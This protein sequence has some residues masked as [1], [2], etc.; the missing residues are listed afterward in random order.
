MTQGFL[1]GR[2]GLAGRRAV[3][4]G[5]LSI[6]GRAVA[7]GLAGAGVDLA[8]FDGDGA[9]LA[10]AEAAARKAGV[11]VFTQHGDVTAS[12]ELSAFY[13]RVEAEFPEGVDIL[14]NAMAGVKRRNFMDT[15]PE[16]WMRDIQQNFAYGLGSMH[17]AVPMMQKRGRG[18]IVNLTTIEAHRGAATF[19]V[20]AGARAAMTNFSRALAVE[21]ADCG[22]RVN[23]LAPDSPPPEVMALVSRVLQPGLAA[24]SPEQLAGAQRMYIPMGRSASVDDVANG[25]LYLASDLA[26]SV[27]GTTLHVD[28][29]T[30]A[31]LGFIN[32]PFGVGYLPSPRGE[33]LR[34]LFPDPG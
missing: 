23:T 25:V 2:A 6:Y 4:V 15:T 18:S 29:G 17:R 26:A 32:W 13:D 31:S 8:L 16:D 1:D 12:A 10:E 22:I 20:Y 27:T 21:L 30:S 24:A 3:L 28:G 14:V 11:N 34:A 9:A 33:A 5:G 19:A 7:A